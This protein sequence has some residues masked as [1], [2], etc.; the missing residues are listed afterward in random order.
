MTPPRPPAY[1]WRVLVAG[2]PQPITLTLEETTAVSRGVVRVLLAAAERAGVTL[3]PVYPADVA[4]P[5]AA[6]EPERE[7]EPA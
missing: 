3:E 2:K 5:F 4:P 1:V 7:P 6:G